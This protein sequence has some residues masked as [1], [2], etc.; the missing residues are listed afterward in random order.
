MG[1]ESM[2]DLRSSAGDG[3]DSTLSLAVWLE[4]FEEE[5]VWLQNGG[6]AGRSVLVMALRT[7]SWLLESQMWVFKRFFC[8]SKDL[9]RISRIR[10]FV[11]QPIADG[12]STIGALEEYEQ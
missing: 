4:Y 6:F 7:K 8:W 3:G 9:W 12:S 11:A 2:V 10:G 5:E 1:A